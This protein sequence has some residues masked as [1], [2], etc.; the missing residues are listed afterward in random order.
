MKPMIQEKTSF[1]GNVQ[2]DVETKAIKSFLSKAKQQKKGSEE[3]VAINESF[4]AKFNGVNI[5]EGTQDL[6]EVESKNNEGV[7]L[8]GI[9]GLGGR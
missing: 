4:G 5:F 6:D 8:T 9:P 2:E 7:D 1:R 3:K